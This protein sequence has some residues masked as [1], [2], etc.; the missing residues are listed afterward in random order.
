[1]QDCNLHTVLRLPRGTFTPYSQGVK[2]NVIFFQKG[3]RP[4]TS[5]S[6]TPLERPRHYEKDAADT[7]HFAEFEQAYGKD[8]NGSCPRTD[9]GRD[10]PLPPLHASEIKERGYKLDITWL[11]DESLEDS[12][13][14]PIPGP[15][16][17]SDHGAGSR[18]RLP[19]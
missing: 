4:R 2:A 6:S 1:M 5:G 3:C 15:R 9:T 16:L 19:S 14:L 10:R 13:D 18:R 12:D 7:G 17:R 11:K 8:P